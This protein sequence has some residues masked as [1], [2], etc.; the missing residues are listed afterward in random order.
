MTI[1][2]NCGYEVTGGFFGGLT[3]TCSCGWRKRIRGQE[4]VANE[5][6]KHRKKYRTREGHIAIR[7]H[8]LDV[9]KRN[10]GSENWMSCGCYWEFRL[11]GTTFEHGVEEWKAHKRRTGDDCDGW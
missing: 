6:D 7:E 4:T 1:E 5:C 8:W 11:D 9:H 3:A 2:H 10:N